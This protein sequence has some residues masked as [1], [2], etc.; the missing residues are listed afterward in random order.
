MGRR[1][2][3]EARDPR[4]PRARSLQ[5][6]SG[7]YSEENR[8]LRNVGNTLPGWR[9]LQAFSRHATGASSSPPRRNWSSSVMRRTTRP[10]SAWKK[11]A[12]SANLAA[13]ST[14]PGSC[15]S[16]LRKAAA[17]VLESSGVG[18]AG[19]GRGPLAPPADSSL[20]G[21]IISHVRGLETA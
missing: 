14:I 5:Y 4:L 1:E 12:C 19:G 15:R 6:R 3:R 9:C 2:G 18:V 8:A 16:F 21:R 13:Y 11:P 17:P 20:V 7:V 10:S